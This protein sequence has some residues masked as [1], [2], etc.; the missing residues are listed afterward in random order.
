MF[1]NNNATR[2]YYKLLNE[3]TALL[4]NADHKSS[5]DVAEVRYGKT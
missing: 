4:F 5:T 2:L 1:F 3:A